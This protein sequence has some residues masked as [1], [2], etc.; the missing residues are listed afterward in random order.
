MLASLVTRLGVAWWSGATAL[1]PPP[2]VP[3][4][5]AVVV[6]GELRGDVHWTSVAT[7][8]L[9]GRV[10]VAAGAT[11]T[12]DAGTLIEAEPG[13]G[14]VVDR[15]SRIDARG[16]LLEPI[17]MRCAN[18]VPQSGC[19][20]GVIIAGNAPVRGGTLTS[21]AVRG[22]GAVGC[23]ELRGDV[24]S[25]RFGGCD[26]ADS[27][28]VLR[29]VR[30]EHA[31][32]GLELLGVGRATIVD[33][34][35]V[36]GSATHGI[37]VRGGTARLTHV[38]STASVGPGWRWTDGWS[39]AA[40]FVAVQR[41]AADTTA[42]V[43][44]ADAP[45]AAA[46]H[47]R[48]LTL[49]GIGGGAAIRLTGAV[50]ATLHNVLAA[51]MGS[52]LDLDGPAACAAAL[53]T[54]LELRG[55][56]GVG[57]GHIADADPDTDCGPAAD[58]ESRAF[59]DAS[60]AVFSLAELAT[61]LRQPLSAVLPDFRSRPGAP[62]PPGTVAPVDG[63]FA[64]PAADIGAFGA[65]VTEAVLPWYSGWSADG[66]P[67]R[68]PFGVITGVLQTAEG[69]AVEGASIL[70]TGSDLSAVTSASGGFTVGLVRPGS[71]MVRAEALPAGCSADSVTVVVDAG[72]SATAMLRADCGPVTITPT[73]IRL[74]YICGN[75]F[76]VRNG[77]AASVVVTWDV[78][79]TPET[80][81]LTLPPRPITGTVS[82]TFF[83]TVARGTVRLMYSGSQVDVKANG[84]AVCTP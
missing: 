54:A 39:G 15:A 28:G 9:R 83:T 80:G 20:M 23:A 51:G 26:P 38:L 82:E 72:G 4:R 84:G 10:A 34:I 14:V 30:I 75:T 42:F 53:T 45:V 48:N 60:P 50:H 47:L 24:V 67:S 73:A 16:T 46:P 36:H 8:R 12:I 32:R 81:T 79:G 40:Q 27:S 21:P 66:E 58:A 7:V 1:V 78:F 13:A 57:L 49:A 74:T 17:V 69:A 22:T 71:R 70:A 33:H 11:L 63:F 65:A 43:E 61:S 2:S 64:T 41:L 19:W 25:G 59:A 52:L 5:P 44:G 35:Q 68:L 37:A 18:G 76:R 3:P 56:V 77:N 6:T 31:S 55:I 29:Y 62:F